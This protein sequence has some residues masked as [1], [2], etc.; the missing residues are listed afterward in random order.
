MTTDVI[1]RLIQVCCEKT[2]FFDCA[3]K[4]AEDGHLLLTQRVVNAKNQAE[5]TKKLRENFKQHGLILVRFK[6][7]TI[8]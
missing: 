6:D 8:I 3:Y 5:A 2:Y 7:L 4:I 1:K